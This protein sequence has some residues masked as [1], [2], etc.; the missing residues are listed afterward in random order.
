MNRFYRLKNE[1]NEYLKDMLIKQP[2][3]FRQFCREI[4]TKLKKAKKNDKL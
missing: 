3:K 4:D 1:K 2:K